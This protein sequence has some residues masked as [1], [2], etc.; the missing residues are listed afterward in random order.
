[1]TNL[2]RVA[3]IYLPVIVRE[4]WHNMEKGT[5]S[6]LVSRFIIA[7]NNPAKRDELMKLIGKD[8]K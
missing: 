8:A 2:P 6:A 1:M 4:V 5:R 3:L 7:Y